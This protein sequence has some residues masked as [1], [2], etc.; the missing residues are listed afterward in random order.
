MSY[1]SE[2]RAQ[3]RQQHFRPTSKPAVPAADLVRKKH[4]EQFAAK[5]IH[6]EVVDNFIRMLEAQTYIQYNWAGGARYEFLSDSGHWISLV[7]QVTSPEWETTRT[8]KLFLELKGG[9]YGYHVW[10]D[11]LEQLRTHMVGCA[12]L[13]AD[14]ESGFLKA[15]VVFKSGDPF[16][17]TIH[18]QEKSKTKGIGP[19][20][21][22][23]VEEPDDEFDISG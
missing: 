2:E 21:E 5:C 6:P 14:K 7:R 20:A 15:G 23:L 11:Y 9:G 22:F 18:K 17:L 8:S 1:S 3:W 10:G 12:L 16:L 19:V 4:N 13:E